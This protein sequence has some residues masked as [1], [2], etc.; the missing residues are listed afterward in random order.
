MVLMRILIGLVTGTLFGAGLAIS[1]MTNPAKVLS[2]LRISAVPAGWDP[3][4][5]LVMGSA[6]GV[7]WLGVVAARRRGRCLCD[8]PIAFPPSSGIDGRLLVGSGLFGVGWGLA[9]LCPGPALA[10]NVSGSWKVALFTI[11][12]IF[13]MGAFRLLESRIATWTGERKRRSESSPETQAQVALFPKSSA[14]ATPL[15][16]RAASEAR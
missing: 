7:S 3:S 13:G 15:I 8:E 10:A 6:L 1:Q 4:L 16:E 2:F 9:G 14:R 12:M 5:A 11:A